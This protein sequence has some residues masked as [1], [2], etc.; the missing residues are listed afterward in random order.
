M[1]A[2]PVRAPVPRSVPAPR[3]APLRAPA[4]A[5]ALAFVLACAC[6]SNK[7]A[8][9]ELFTASKSASSS[10]ST[11]QTSSKPSETNKPA[12]A[13]A[14]TPADEAGP[15][16]DECTQLLVVTTESWNAID[17][18]LQRY[19]RKP[20]QAWQAVGESVASVVGRTGLAWGRGEHAALVQEGAPTALVHADDPIKH[21]GDGKS[22]AGVFA[23][24]KAYGYDSSPPSG[25]SLPYQKT[26]ADWLCVNDS[27]SRQYN[28]VL[29]TQGV[30]KDWSEAEQM[31]RKDELYRLVIEVD[32]N[33]IVPSEM[34]PVP[35]GGSCIFLHVWRKAGA[36]TIGC[37]AM[38]LPDMQSVMSWLEPAKHPLLVALPRDRYQALQASW[39][40]P[41]LVAR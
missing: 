10:A 4:L 22:P 18:R 1:R 40:L 6:G 26:S 17:S 29:D 20:G 8:Q 30:D 15:I 25:T 23:I 32:H 16:G 28:R 9:P 34:A 14:A 19:E 36:P 13:D 7:E 41:E 12:P 3:R 39:Q 2:R 38:A 21:E 24:G 35:E 31:R 33:R 11:S 37:T 5:P 27:S